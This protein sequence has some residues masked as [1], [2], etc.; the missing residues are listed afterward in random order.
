MLGSKGTFGVPFNLIESQKPL[1]KF[2][3]NDNPYESFPDISTLDVCKVELS[4][5]MA[6]TCPSMMQFYDCKGFDI[7]GE[8]Y[9]A[10]L[11]EFIHGENGSDFIKKPI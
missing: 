10:I 9:V 2:L 1:I 7:G 11:M 8:H 6:P 5:K 3:K 4:L